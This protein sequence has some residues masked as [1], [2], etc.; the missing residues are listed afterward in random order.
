M[1]VKVPVV[2]RSII[3]SLLFGLLTLAVTVHCYSW[4]IPLLRE[5]R[6]ARRRS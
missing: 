1:H 3:A 6:R 2:L 4:I 5:R